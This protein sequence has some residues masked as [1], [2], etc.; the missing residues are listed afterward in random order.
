MPRPI[1][2]RRS[3]GFALLVVLWTVALLALLGS[4]ITAGARRAVSLGM[5]LHDAAQAEALADG[6]VFEAIFRL[7]D[8]SPRG[9]KADGV[10]RSVRLGGGRGEVT[11][12][13]HAG[14]VNPSLA[15]P[16]LLTA[17]LRLDGVPEPRAAR[18]AAALTDWHTADPMPLPGGAKAPQ[19][20]AAGLPYA[21]PNENYHS[22]AELGLV[23][24]MTPDVLARLSPHLSIWNLGQ[25]DLSRADPVVVRAVQDTAS[26][27]APPRPAPESP[28]PPML[29]EIVARVTLPGARTLRRAVVYITP[30]DEE[31]P[32]PW[33]FLAWE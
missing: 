14:R 27:A 15:P 31:A 9:W 23:L 20:R 7:L 32:R 10:P 22:P 17:L 18:L 13:D 26:D 5:L 12:L 8:P 19:Y 25:I 29:V 24:G 4:H 11:V 30:G 1:S 33:H 16:K 2:P 28:L 21:P 6:L 3:P